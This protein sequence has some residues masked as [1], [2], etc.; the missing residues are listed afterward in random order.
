VL[1]DIKVKSGQEVKSGQVLFIIQAMKMENE[2]T[3][4]RDG[5]VDDI[6]VEMGV[7]VQTGTVLAMYAT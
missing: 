5:K 4:P 3:A 1:S 2:I 6:R 7:S